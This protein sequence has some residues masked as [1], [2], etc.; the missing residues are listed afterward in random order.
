LAGPKFDLQGRHVRIGLT[1][2][3]LGIGLLAGFRMIGSYVDQDGFVHEPFALL[4]IGWL[5]VLL[6]AIGV[7][8]AKIRAARDRRR[9]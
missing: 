3:L 6:G 4:A 5:C 2:L 9:S 1:L 8:V 7:V